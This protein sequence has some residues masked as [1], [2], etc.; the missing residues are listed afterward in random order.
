M[1]TLFENDPSSSKLKDYV[2]L[3]FDLAVIGEGGKVENPAL[4]SKRV[5]ELM[6]QSV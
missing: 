1:K 5:G 3:I 6:N 2:G 4:F